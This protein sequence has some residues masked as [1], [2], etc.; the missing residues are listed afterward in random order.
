M[1]FVEDVDERFKP[2]TRDEHAM[3][4][5]ESSINDE[6]DSFPLPMRAKD[7]S[8]MVNSILDRQVFTYKYAR[9]W[10]VKH[11]SSPL[12]CCCRVR[13]RKDDFLQRE[14][15]LKLNAEID[16]LEILKKLRVHQ[17]AAE[18]TL[19]PWQRNLVNFFSQYTLATPEELEEQVKVYIS[20]Q[21]KGK[22]LL[23][24]NSM[25]SNITSQQSSQG[26]L[27]GVGANN[28]QD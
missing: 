7:E 16:V 6:I 19:K 4:S 14:A 18:V 28:V 17:F 5:R 3:E 23:R 12:F 20:Q 10:L 26:G 9:M 13:L 15:K 8:E 2:S 11:F 24:A 21:R 27:L 1:V 22:G 25:T